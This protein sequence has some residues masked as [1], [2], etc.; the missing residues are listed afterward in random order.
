MRCEGGADRGGEFGDGG[1]VRDGAAWRGI[2]CA[3]RGT[4]GA[5]DCGGGLRAVM[6][7]YIFRIQGHVEE[8]LT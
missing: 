7:G 8:R 4:G 2:E 6:L 1:A 5:Y 3:M